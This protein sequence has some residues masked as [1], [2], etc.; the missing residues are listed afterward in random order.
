MTHTIDP[1]A[2]CT[3]RFQHENLNVALD[4]P[5]VSITCQGAMRVM[6]SAKLFDTK[7]LLSPWI[8]WVRGTPYRSTPGD[9]SQTSRLDTSKIQ[10]GGGCALQVVLLASHARVSE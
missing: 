1:K 4:I 9:S 5:L 2:N 8:L 10:T 7:I 3:L 6:V